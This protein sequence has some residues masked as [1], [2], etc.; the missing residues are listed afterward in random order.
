MLI[1]IK[2][3][4][5]VVDK[6]PTRA[7]VVWREA[8][9]IQAKLSWP[10]MKQYMLAHAKIR[11]NSSKFMLHNSPCINGMVSPNLFFFFLLPFSFSRF[12][13]FFSLSLVFSLYKRFPF[14]VSA[15]SHLRLFSLFAGN[16]C[17]QEGN[18]E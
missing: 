3:T 8:E 7:Q 1:L 13:F 2:T 11:G 5:E 17:L 9:P 15:T 10:V 12:F 14:L 4:S 16:A 6:L 18:D